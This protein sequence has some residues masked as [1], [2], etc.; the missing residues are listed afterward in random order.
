MTSK[1][2]A[3]TATTALTCGAALLAVAACTGSAAAIGADP[4]GGEGDLAK[5]SAQQV[6][7][8]A[9]HELLGA[10]SLRLRTQAS[11]DPTRLD[12]S[13][14]RDSNCTGS[15][16]KGPLGRVELI[17]RGAQVWMKPDAAFWK[18]QLPG[19][20]GDDA[21]KQ[22]EGR[23]L[24][25][26][27]DDAFLKQLSAACDLKSFQKQIAGPSDRPSTPPPSGG[28]PSASSPALKKG[29]PTVHEGSRVLPIV[30]K[31]GPVTQTLYVAIEGKHYPLKLTAAADHQTGTIL[32][33][34]FGTPVPGKTPAAGDTLDISVLE[35]RVK[36]SSPASP[37]GLP[38]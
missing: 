32:L 33:S 35:K 30:K 17:K 25:G 29:K 4:D 26:T 3:T 23:Y 38:G 36:K 13:L 6:S 9:L 2:R 10:T 21:A 12:L 16:S 37:A 11:G 19:A 27:T 8:D 34:N 18:G 24:H 14:D 7:D 28:S 1:H 5:K 20:E 15:I 22:Y 31:S